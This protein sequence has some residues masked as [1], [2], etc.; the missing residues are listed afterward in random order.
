MGLNPAETFIRNRRYLILGAPFDL[1]AHGF[2]E[3]QGCLRVDLCKSANGIDGVQILNRQRVGI[4][5]AMMK[6]ISFAYSLSWA[7]LSD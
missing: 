4:V 2:P 1:I 5:V 3:I 7:A 6:A